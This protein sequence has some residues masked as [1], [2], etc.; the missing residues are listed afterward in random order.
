MHNLKAES[1][2]LSGRLSEDSSPGSSLSALKDCSK[3]VREE[4]GYLRVF[5]TKTRESEHQKIT[6]N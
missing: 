1:C 6:V 3:E 2:V 5:E 4:P